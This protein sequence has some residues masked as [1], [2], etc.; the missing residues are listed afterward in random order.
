MRR[1]TNRRI[2]PVRWPTGYPAED[3]F[4]LREGA[5]PEP[6]PGQALIRTLWLSLDPYMRVRLTDRKN[7]TLNEPMIGAVVA[8]VERDHGSGLGVGTFVEA[9][10]SWQDY[11][12]VA[13]HQVR[14]VD[15]ALAPLSTALGVLG[16]PGL[17]AW[18]GITEVACPKPGETVLVSAAAGAVG[19]L[20]GQLARLMGC[21]VVGTAGSDAKVRHVVDDLGFAAAINYRVPGLAAA[22]AKACPDGIDVY[23]DNVGGDVAWAAFDLLTMNARVAVCGQASQYNLTEPELAPRDLFWLIAKRARLQ[24]FSIWSYADRYAE[25]LA[26]LAALYK[27][28]KLVYREDVVDGLENA[29]RTFIGLLQGHNLGKQLIKVSDAPE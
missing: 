21:R 26:R 16:M 4:A 20:A 14:R 8:V 18:F 19:S 2:V 17:T 12:C 29:P 3:D 6:A 10:L 1:N 9:R 5:I 25:G 11:H 7:V 22:L 24:G 28:G 27:A 15:P 13:E 23:F